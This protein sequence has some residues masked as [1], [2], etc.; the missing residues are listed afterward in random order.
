M[1]RKYDFIGL[2]E[3]FD[4]SLV[5]MKLLLG[6]E[7]SD[8]LYFAANRKEDF[9]PAGRR[10]K[11]C[12]KSFDWETDLIT[13]PSIRDYVKGSKQW[14]AQNYGDYLIYQAAAQSLD[15]TILKIGLDLFSRELKSFRILMQRA[16]EECSPKFACSSN[17]TQQFLEAEYDCIADGKFGCGHRC[18]DGITA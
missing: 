3:R 12:R 8:I 10:K 1:F 6:L 14:Y 2:V 7:S 9:R 16:E 13:E 15:K 18:L 4:E 17:G 11:V 5:V